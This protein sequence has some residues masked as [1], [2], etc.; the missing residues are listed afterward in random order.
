[1]FCRYAE[2]PFLLAR[3]RDNS[4]F[5]AWCAAPLDATS[6]ETEALAPPLP[7]GSISSSS[8]DEGRFVPG[9]MLAGRYRIAGLLGRGG[10]GESIAPRT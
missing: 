2:L 1:L 10:M 7:P 8:V 9:T 5:C 4:R 6:A 3:M